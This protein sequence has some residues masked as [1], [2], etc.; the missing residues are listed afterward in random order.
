MAKYTIELSQI[1]NSLTG[2]LPPVPFSKIEE[3]IVKAAP[4]VFD[5]T[6]PF[7]TEDS[8]IKKEFQENFLRNFYFQEIAHETYGRWKM[9]LQAKLFEIMPKYKKMHDIDSQKYNIF[10]N[11][12]MTKTGTTNGTTNAT[13]QL[14]KTGNN[15]NKSDTTQADTTANENIDEYSATPQGGLNG[16]R[17]GSYL[18]EARIIT[19]N[20]NQKVSTNINGSTTTSEKTAGNNTSSKED[21]FTETWQGKEGGTDYAEIKMKE[22]EAI[23]N[24][25]K[26]IFD[27]LECLFMGVF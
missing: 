2:V 8:V 12:K 6:Y 23:V 10:D 25:N 7:Y 13:S 3:S 19:D 9:R 15:T 11:T 21:T 1:I 24:I 16:V 14:D 18:T 26:L 27:D 17:D 4:L 5:F 22:Y 20:S